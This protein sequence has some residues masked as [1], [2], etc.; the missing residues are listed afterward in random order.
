MWHS[1]YCGLDPEDETG[2]FNKTRAFAIN[3]SSVFESHTLATLKKASENDSLSGQPTFIYS[4]FIPNVGLTIVV[5]QTL[6]I[7]EEGFTKTVITWS[8]EESITCFA[9]DASGQFLFVG[10]ASLCVCCIHIA[11]SISVFERDLPNDEGNDKILRIDHEQNGSVSVF[12]ATGQIYRFA[13]I[14]LSSFDTICKEQEGNEDELDKVAEDIE[15][16]ALFFMEK[17]TKL[18]ELINCTATLEDEGKILLANSAFHVLSSSSNNKASANRPV[19]YLDYIPLQ[20]MKIV[21]LEPIDELEV[22]L[23]LTHDGRLVLFCQQTWTIIHECSLERVH[24]FTIVNDLTEDREQSVLIAT[25]G[26]EIMLLTLPGLTIVWSLKD[27]QGAAYHVIRNKTVLD[28]GIIY[29]ET[30][31]SQGSVDQVFIKAMVKSRP[32]DRLERMLRRGKFD[33]AYDFARLVNLDIE[34]IHKARIQRIMSDLQSITWSKLHPPESDPVQELFKTLLE[35]LNGIKDI[36]FIVVCCINTLPPSIEM[37]RTL[38]MHARTRLGGVDIKNSSSGLHASVV[39]LNTLLTRLNTYHKIHAME[40]NSDIELWL[41]FSKATLLD[42]VIEFLKKGNIDTVIVL[43]LRHRTEITESLAR[44]KPKLLDL[45]HKEVDIPSLVKLLEVIMSELLNTSK[46]HLKYLVAWAYEKTRL[47]E[48]SAGPGWCETSLNFC[49]SI[50]TLIKTASQRSMDIT[51]GQSCSPDSPIQSL[52]SLIKILQSLTLLKTQFNIRMPF[53]EYCQPNKLEVVF[54]ILDRTDGPQIPSLFSTFLTTFLFENKLSSD[55]VLTEY[56]IRLLMECSV[57]WWHSEDA[58]WEDKISVLLPLVV[59]AEKRIRVIINVLRRSPVPWSP[60][61]LLLGEAGLKASSNLVTA[62]QAEYN[63]VPGKLILKKY[64]IKQDLPPK[65]YLSRLIRYIYKQNKSTMLSD[66]VQLVQSLD[67]NLNFDPYELY[68]SNILLDT[69]RTDEA[70]DFLDDPALLPEVVQACCKVI[71]F[72]THRLV[73]NQDPRADSYVTV[74]ESVKQRLENIYAKKRHVP[75]GRGLDEYVKKVK[76]VSVLGREFSTCASVTDLCYPGTREMVLRS[77]LNGLNETLLTASGFG[78][79]EV[80]AVLSEVTLKKIAFSCCVSYE[81]TLITLIQQTSHNHYAKLAQFLLDAHSVGSEHMASKLLGVT[82]YLLCYYNPKK[83]P[84]LRDVLL[85]AVCQLSQIMLTYIHPSLLIKA[86]ELHQWVQL[87]KKQNLETSISEVTVH[88]F[89]TTL[90]N[91]YRYFLCNR[92]CDT[93]LYISETAILSEGDQLRLSVNLALQKLKTEQPHDLVNL[94]ILMIFSSA[95]STVVSSDTLFPDI[96]ELMHLCI[97]RLIRKVFSARTLDSK[98]GVALLSNFSPSE[99]LATLQDA[100]KKY[101]TDMLPLLHVSCLGMEYAAAHSMVSTYAR[102]QRLNVKCVWGNRISEF[103][104]SY[105][106]AFKDSDENK[107]LLVQRLASDPN[108]KVSMLHDFCQDMKVN[109]QECLLYFLQQSLL[110]WQPVFQIKSDLG[111][112]KQLVVL[113]DVQHVRAMCEEV[114]SLVKDMKQLQDVLLKTQDKLNWYNYE[115]YLLLCDLIQSVSARTKTPSPPPLYKMVHVLVFLSSY[116]RN[117]APQEAE[118]NIWAGSHPEN[119]NLPDIASYRLPFP[120]RNIKNID[121]WKIL[122]PELNMSTYLIW[123][124]VVDYMG[125]DKDSLCTMAVNQMCQDESLLPNKKEEWSLHSSFSSLLDSIRDCVDK[126]TDPSMVTCALNYVVTRLPPGA[127]QVTAVQLCNERALEWYQTTKSEEAKKKLI[128]VQKKFLSVHTT[129]TLYSAG[130]AKPEYLQK[131]TTPVPL[132]TSLYHDKSVL[133]FHATSR[134]SLPDIN[135]VTDAIAKL[136]AVD[137]VKIRQDLLS[138]WLSCKN[139]LLDAS[140]SD[141]TTV[142]A[143]VS[144]NPCDDDNFIRACYILQRDEFC[145]FLLSRAFPE[146]DSQP[147][148]V[149]L[150]ALQCLF[151]IKSR[152]CLVQL[153]GRGDLEYYLEDLHFVMELENLGSSYS[154][155]EFQSWSKPDLIQ[156]LIARS[157][158]YTTRLALK[159][160]LHYQVKEAPLIHEILK[161]MM[162]F[163]M[164]DE[165]VTFLPQISDMNHRLSEGQISDMWNSVVDT[166]LSKCHPNMENFDSEF[167]QIL[168]TIISC[169][170]EDYLNMENIEYHLRRLNRLKA[171][172]RLKNDTP[173]SNGYAE[174]NGDIKTSPVS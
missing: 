126:I 89:I 167:E 80:N 22:I 27:D 140:L 41:K 171:M 65:Q 162:A 86:T 139:Q 158:T 172:S 60:A 79:D 54:D 87:F 143:T 107:R 112:K 44:T 142:H 82:S 37:I 38:L 10:L 85:P 174:M 133:L 43:W 26:P 25:D 100:E 144:L 40:C 134:N 58:G 8:G 93:S 29:V 62:V 154:M 101:E 165:L 135:S 53:A 173:L 97:K 152:D 98:L 136:H 122:K 150:R 18:R 75:E 24:D 48:R 12:T 28:D 157:N 90:L 145:P 163:N 88:H 124:D 64:G 116:V 32:E 47:L 138:E 110:G 33:A 5:D 50:L 119:E 111:G 57:N 159:L 106:E 23:C 34:I 120:V 16:H 109:T 68:V 166:L 30:K 55:S 153:T 161:Q 19:E 2:N 137:I 121:F 56:N 128:K 123:Y 118:R 76:D 103:G 73:K 51:S 149:R 155:E 17:K 113:N 164:V 102:Y 70:M 11:T 71:I 74:V 78:P 7:Y 72:R 94:R 45:I 168:N 59:N 160:I 117:A 156:N 95:L 9:V 131:V 108:M 52:L 61:V 83:Q 21:K 146:T 84:Q 105:K 114:M 20:D 4:Q 81:E 92:G 130:L 3:E 6:I 96:P 67:S 15:I 13:K 49:Q 36:E 69:G 66:A 151:A 63:L 99:A 91:F 42:E 169:P 35:S 129:H 1:D 14:N 77:V 31:Q 127:D 115:I 132:I 125:L 141:V 147:T 170:Q 148:S 39:E 104:I 46:Q